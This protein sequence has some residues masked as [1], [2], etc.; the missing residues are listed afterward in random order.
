[1]HGSMTFGDVKIRCVSCNTSKAHVS[2]RYE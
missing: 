2:E 1:V